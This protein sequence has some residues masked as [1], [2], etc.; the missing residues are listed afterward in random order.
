MHT[1][2]VDKSPH[3]RDSAG[4]GSWLKHRLAQILTR[5]SC[6]THA[7]SDTAFVSLAKANADTHHHHQEEAPP[8]PYFCT[9]CTYERP[10]VDGAGGRP[11]RRRSRSASLVHISVDCTGG[12]AVGASGRRSVH[13]D[14]PLL[15]QHCPSSLP[16]RDGAKKQQ[17]RR[18][19]SKPPAAA[20]RH[21]STTSDAWGRARRPWTAPTAPY[22]YG[23]SS[24]SSSTAT[25]DELAPFSSDDG[26]KE[27]AETRTLF[28]SLSFSSESTSDFYQTNNNN[29]RTTRRVN[30]ATRHGPRRALPRPPAPADAFRPLISV[31]AKKQHG[32]CNVNR[33]AKEEE[34]VTA[35]KAKPVVAAEEAAG[36]G[37]AVVKRSSNPYADFRSSMVEM[38]V[39]RRIASVNQMEELLGSYLQLNSQR[40]HPAI[41]AA[42]EDVWE[43]VFGDE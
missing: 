19:S 7:N 20:R 18:R 24:S 38:V 3:R 14:A 31:E 39:E 40:H 32:G 4:A 1:P 12:A 21:C 11:R 22:P 42:F 37:M 9:P 34:G 28:S 15:Q 16:A 36:P 6:A 41:L 30:A 33:K 26:E 13:S 2:L 10:K 23:W 29:M 35:V 17:S 25:D 27:E 8:S 5:S 43:A